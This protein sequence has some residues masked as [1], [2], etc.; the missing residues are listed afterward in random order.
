MQ[1]EM[2]TGSMMG[3]CQGRADYTSAGHCGVP[4]GVNIGVGVSLVSPV[5]AVLLRDSQE[6]GEKAS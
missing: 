2:C 5:K 1:V 4:D 3:L 6:A